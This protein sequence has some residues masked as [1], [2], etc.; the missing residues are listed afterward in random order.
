MCQG[1]YNCVV[2][3]A[4]LQEVGY[5]GGISIP[6]ENELLLSEQQER[7]PK[8]MN[9]RLE[10][11]RLPHHKG[12]ESGMVVYY[13]TLSHLIADLKNAQSQ[14]H[15]DRRWRVYPRPAVLVIDEVG[16]MQ[17]DQQE[18]ELLFRLISLRAWQC[19]SHQLQQLGELLSYM[20]WLPSC[21]TGCCTMLMW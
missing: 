15:L 3:L 21:W 5:D 12:I 9:T 16:Y 2:L 4:R 11:A 20:Y 13:T 17:L 19:D 18:A 8:N 10:P 7:R 1:I 14:G 6:K